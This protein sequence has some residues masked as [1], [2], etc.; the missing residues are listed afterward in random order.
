MEQEISK[1]MIA[2]SMANEPMNDI[3]RV[4]EW[5]IKKG[6]N[7]DEDV[8]SSENHNILYTYFEKLSV[9]TFYYEG[10][11]DN[12]FPEI[13]FE[14]ITLLQDLK[15]T[16]VSI[17]EESYSGFETLVDL[18]LGKFIKVVLKGD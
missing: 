11:V 13:I 3:Q 12:D 4:K 1:A 16:K 15:D 5:F 14:F 7:I 9:L 2:I 18:P 6:Y 8:I 10:N 17:A